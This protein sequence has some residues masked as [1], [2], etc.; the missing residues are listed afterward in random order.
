MSMKMDEQIFEVV[1]IL[2][3]AFA[4]ALFAFV[5]LKFAERGKDKKEK[6]KANIKAL[7]KIQQICNENYNLLNDTLF[8]INEIIKVIEEARK[9]NQSPFSANRLDTLV[10]DKNILLDLLNNDF[11]NDY[12]SY[13]IMVKKQNDDVD[14]TNNFHESMKMA[15]LT[16]K[17]TS[18]NYIQNM[19]RFEDNLKVEKKFIDDSMKQTEM[20]LAR[21]RVLLKEKTTIFRK[22]FKHKNIG[23]NK[24]FNEKYEKELKSLKIELETIKQKSKDEIENVIKSE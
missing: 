16:D 20:I 19:I 23:Y 17:I 8:S 13:M 15:R 5:F 10:I 2:L 21:C 11:V 3:S 9:R 12:F 24:K 18:E 4:G 1:K 22:I 7:S 14:S 6:Q